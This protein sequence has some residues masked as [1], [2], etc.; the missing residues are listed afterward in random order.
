MNIDIYTD[1]ACQPNPG[2]TGSGVVIYNAGE[3]VKMF[4]GAHESLGTNNTAELT[5]LEMGLIQASEILSDGSVANIT[6][7]SDS[8]YSIDCLTTWIDGWIKKGWKNSKKQ[9]VKNKEIIQA[10]Y[11]IYLPIKEQI[12]IAHIK[13]HAGHEGN[14]LSDRMAVYAVHKEITSWVDFKFRD[15]KSVLEMP[16][17]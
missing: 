17:G 6:L 1:G 14:E 9:D 10:M 2:K 8:K 12:T 5:A 7:Y 15:V 13:G 11:K 3:V 4:T 16:S